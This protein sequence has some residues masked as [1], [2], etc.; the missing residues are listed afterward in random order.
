[1][2]VCHYS[3]TRLRVHASGRCSKQAPINT[4]TPSICPSESSLKCYNRLKSPFPALRNPR[5]LFAGLFSP[6]SPSDL[7]T[8]NPNNNTF[9]FVSGSGKAAFCACDDARG[10]LEPLVLL[11][12]E[13]LLGDVGFAGMTSGFGFIAWTSVNNLACEQYDG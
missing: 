13:L 1:M 7:L 6:S 12:W 2:N 10:T 5:L 11:A 9:G 3:I 8:P 4:P